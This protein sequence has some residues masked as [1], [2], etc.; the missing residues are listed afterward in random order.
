METVVYSTVFFLPIF[1]ES[2]ICHGTKVVGLTSLQAIFSEASQAKQRRSR[3]WRRFRRTL[4]S[5][6][7]GTE[8]RVF[9]CNNEMQVR[10]PCWDAGEAFQF[11]EKSGVVAHTWYAYCFEF[12]V[13]CDCSHTPCIQ[14]ILAG[15]RAKVIQ[16]A[17][18]QF[19]VAAVILVTHIFR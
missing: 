15:S 6:F 19:A 5:P 11:Q 4:L 2:Q 7:K 10:G 17:R 1:G 3:S 8:Q 14:C 16:S 13:P 18:A 12:G 9:R